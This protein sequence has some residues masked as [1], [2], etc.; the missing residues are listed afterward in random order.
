MKAFERIGVVDCILYDGTKKQ[1]REFCK[2][3]KEDM[4]TRFFYDKSVASMFVVSDYGIESI[5]KGDYL[6]RNARGDYYP[7]EPE[8]F[9][10]LYVS[11]VEKP[12]KGNHKK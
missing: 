12:K 5:H 3:F 1:L 10:E 9:N 8:K 11:L 7:I 6:I 2:L 4:E